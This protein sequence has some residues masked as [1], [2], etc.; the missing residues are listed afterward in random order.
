MALD[1]I[2]PGDR[3]YEGARHV[4]GATGSLAEIVRPRSAEE[5]A[6]ALAFARGVGGE[7][8]IRSGGHGISSISTNDGGTVIDLSALASV[9]RTGDRTVRLG[10]GARWG[11]VAR[12]LDQ[13]GLAISSGDS[14]DVG[15]GGLATTGGLGLMGRLHGLTIDSLESAEIVVADGRMLTVSAHENP[16]LFW[17]V[18]GAG[19][20]FG[21]VT[22]FAFRAATT[23]RVARAQFQYAITDLVEFLAAWG[24]LV[25]ISEREISAF[26]YLFTGPQAFAQATVVYAGSDV[27]AA[28]SALEPFGALP[29]V[30]G[31]RAELVPYAEVP[32]T[33][34]AVHTGQ[35]TAVTRTGLANHL[36]EG[37]SGALA[38]MMSGGA[39]QM[40]QIRSA[41]GA[42]N[43]VAEDA[44]AYAHRHQ[45]F[46]VTAVSDRSAR[47]ALDRAW[48]P[49]SQLMDGMYLSF[50]S[51][52][53]PA[54][55]LEAFPPR[56]LERLRALKAEWDPDA[57]F[58][59]NFD[60]R[61]LP[62][63]RASHR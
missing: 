11:Q 56:T 14:G 19:A 15:V 23:H 33:S 58:T 40:L 22:S 24:A 9:V 62:S 36:D 21:I 51:D 1:I 20:N 25:E 8:S 63:E 2:R 54:H 47:P 18:R 28:T 30:I 52:H 61:E 49:A 35:Q 27:P 55:V 17:A 29:G 16:D 50:E 7:L 44:T 38:A 41:G 53:T 6:A 26:L 39:V 48:A 13:W 34:G 31:Q 59:Q 3:R 42:I 43:D 32:L 4:Y 60:V 45:N 46:S 12:T 37:M 5:V 10:P 57:V